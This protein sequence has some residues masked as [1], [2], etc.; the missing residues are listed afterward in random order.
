MKV[1][2]DFDEVVKPT[3]VTKK[4]WLYEDGMKQKPNFYKC[5]KKEGKPRIK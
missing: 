3:R 1:Y 5:K 4:L 2:K